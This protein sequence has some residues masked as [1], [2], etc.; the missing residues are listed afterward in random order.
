[1]TIGSGTDPETDLGPLASRK[2]YDK[3][4]EYV[5]IGKQEGATVLYEGEL[6]TDLDDGYYV[7]PVVFGDVTRDMRIAREEIFG[8]VL[9]VH[10]Y[11]T[12]EEAIE[13]A[14]DT[15]YG[16]TAAVWSQNMEVAN[17]VA[18]RLEVGLVFVN[19]FVNGFLGAPFG[20]YGRSGIGRKLG[21]EETMDEFTRVKTVRSSIA[22][23]TT[24]SL[25]DYYD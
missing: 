17:R 22:E 9:T 13:T 3:V 18:R 10:R 19:N 23:S 8:P 4:T 14:N 7:P 2:Q 21:F 16:L 11:E 25:D 20:G 15:D 6:P 1:M 5:N 12:V 24:G